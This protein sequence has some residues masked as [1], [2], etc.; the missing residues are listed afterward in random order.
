MI[1]PRHPSTT[2]LSVLLYSC[3]W[4]LDYDNVGQCIDTVCADMPDEYKA[5]LYARIQDTVLEGDTMA[6]IE[7]KVTAALWSTERV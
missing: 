6:E 2:V 7:R 1:N 4:A 3:R 5:E